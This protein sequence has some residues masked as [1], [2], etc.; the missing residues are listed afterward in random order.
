MARGR[1]VGSSLKDTHDEPINPL[2]PTSAYSMAR[3]VY[4]DTL[5]RMIQQGIERNIEYDPS[6]EEDQFLHRIDADPTRASPSELQRAAAILNQTTRNMQYVL[7]HQPNLLSQYNDLLQEYRRA[8]TT[9]AAENP[10]AF[11]DTTQPWHVVQPRHVVEPWRLTPA[12]RDTLLLDRVQNAGGPQSAQEAGRVNAILR[13]R[14]AALTRST[15]HGGSLESLSTESLYQRLVRRVEEDPSWN[16]IR[17]EG[18]L[19]QLA[20][21]R[22]NRNALL[23]IKNSHNINLS[24][25]AF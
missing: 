6:S 24:P 23:Y 21:N 4:N 8:Y 19:T 14:L 17:R 18:I 13:T 9:F 7:Q 3:R 20:R 12:Q 10:Q 5:Q 25:D 1:G 11:H 15:T 2:P 16:N 22:G